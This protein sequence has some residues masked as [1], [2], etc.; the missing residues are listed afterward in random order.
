M[1]RISYIFV[2]II[3][4]SC[5]RQDYD[6]E[7]TTLT[8]ENQKFEILTAWII[9]DDYIKNKSN[10]ENDVFLKIE[11]EFDNYNSEFPFLLDA[12]KNKISPNDE[13]KEEIELMKSIDF[14]SIVDS[15]YRIVTKEL[16]GPDT[17]ILFIPANPANRKFYREF[18]VGFHA[19]TLGSGKII[20]SFDPTFENWRQYIHYALAHEYHHSV[21]ISRNFKNADIS[22]LE[23]IILEGK[24]DLFANEIFPKNKN[25]FWDMFDGEDEKSIWNLIKPEMN[26]RN[27]D[28]NDKIFYGSKEIP[29]GSVYAIGYKILKLFKKNNPEITTL[30][31]IDMS[32]ESILQLSKYDE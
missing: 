8:I 16:P 26:Q 4:I 17:K 20:I 32:P 13:L 5:Q 2:I 18:G 14:V 9:L 28:M 12:I 25:P 21:W 24:A 15:V 31:I 23:Y 27:T 7:R 3:F 1:K 11:E 29:Y 19:F 6:F 22:P 10:Y 30:E